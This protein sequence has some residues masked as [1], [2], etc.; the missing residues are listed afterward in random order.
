VTK[1]VVLADCACAGAAAVK[2]AARQ[3]HAA[4]IILV[5]VD[6]DSSGLF[7]A[8]YFCEL[9]LRIAVAISLNGRAG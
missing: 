4:E 9:F 7:F 3:K 2:P 6:I 8:G 5:N 1:K